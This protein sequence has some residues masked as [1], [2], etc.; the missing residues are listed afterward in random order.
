MLTDTAFLEAYTAIVE[1]RR[2]FWH[3]VPAGYVRVS[4]PDRVDFLHRQTTND[5]NHLGQGMVRHNVLTSPTGR[6]L[7]AFTMIAEPESIALI[8]PP[9]GAEWLTDYLRGRI[10]FMDD[11]A[12]EDASAEVVQFDVGGD[13]AEVTL[14]ALGISE[15]PSGELLGQD[16]VGSVLAF[17]MS[18]EPPL[19]N[20]FRV[21]SP[22]DMAADITGRLE[23]AGGI[24]LQG[25][26]FDLLRIEAGLPAGGRELTDSYTPLEVG[27]RDWVSSDKGCYTGQEVIARQITYDKVTRSL[28]GVRLESSVEAGATLIADGRRCGEVTSAAVSPR[29]GPIALA[30][31]RRPAVSAGT[32]VTA[33]EGDGALP[34]IVC[35]LPFT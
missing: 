4:G 11:V 2:Y 7:V 12:V 14:R 20:L 10:F 13:A 22:A 25:E 27:L 26:V 5:V 28:V 17:A 18:A 21:I 9:G 16:E 19:D 32:A 15:A 6:I 8:L 24:A 30:V 3:K 23:T 33:E 29:F 31:V 35:E 1:K 34:G